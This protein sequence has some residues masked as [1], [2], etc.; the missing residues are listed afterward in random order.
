MHVSLIGAA[1]LAILLRLGLS[2]RTAAVVS[3]ILMFFYGLLT[4]FAPATLRAV[5]M[6]TAVNLS[7]VFR[8]TADLPTSAGLSMFLIEEGAGV[9]HPLSESSFWNALR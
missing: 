6:L 7:G 5:W 8:R 1:V 9:P 2:R 3:I 4:G